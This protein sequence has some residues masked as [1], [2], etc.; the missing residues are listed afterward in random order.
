VTDHFQRLGLKAH[1][2]LDVAA[3]EARHRELALVHH[4]D[5]QTPGDAKARLRAAE[6]T[7]SLNEALKTLKDPVRRGV[8]LLKLHGVDLEKDEAGGSGKL[9]QGF[10]AEIL[11]LREALEDARAAK[12]LE[13]VQT[14][15]RQIHERQAGT[16]ESARAALRRLPAADAIAAATPLL[17]QLKYF[18]RF[19]EEV[20]AIE[21]EALG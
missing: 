17:A 16:L 14:L 10:L 19:L 9:P 6:E 1:V 7:A 2:D 8:Y 11:D 4:P 20:D 5:R 15:A 12:D 18:T 13:K 21:E 3:L